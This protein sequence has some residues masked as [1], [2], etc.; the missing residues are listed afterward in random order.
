MGLLLRPHHSR[1]VVQILFLQRYSTCIFLC[2]CQHQQLQML[3]PLREHGQALRLFL[4]QDTGNLNIFFPSCLLLLLTA[5]LLLSTHQNC[6]QPCLLLLLCVLKLQRVSDVWRL[7]SILL[8]MYEHVM[9]S[10]CHLNIQNS[11]YK[12]CSKCKPCKF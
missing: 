9:M 5:V 2:G 4:L 7:L 3:F 11:Q 8:K 10:H 12:N 1:C 6:V